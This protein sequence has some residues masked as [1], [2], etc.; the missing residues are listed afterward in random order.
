VTKNDTIKFQN[1]N[2]NPVTI[3][4]TEEEI[5]NCLKTISKLDTLVS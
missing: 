1:E 5:K 4:V 2:Q 3:D